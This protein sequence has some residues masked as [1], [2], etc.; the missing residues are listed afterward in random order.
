M[1][2]WEGVAVRT[3]KRGSSEDMGGGISRGCP[4]ISRSGM[5]NPWS[6]VCRLKGWTLT[7][8]V[9]KRHGQI[10]KYINDANILKS[11]IFGMNLI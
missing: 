3:P 9:L 11:F 7:K 5:G 4:V 6:P 1:R 2:T 8:S 10:V